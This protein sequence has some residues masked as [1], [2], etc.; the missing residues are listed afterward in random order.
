MKAFHISSFLLLS[1]LGVFSCSEKKAA[2]EDQDYL[3]ITI[4]NENR[5]LENIIAS[6]IEAR[7]LGA[8]Y[9]WTEGPLWVEEEKMLLFSEI[10]AN[11]VHV[12][13]EGGAPE[14]YLHPA[15]LTTGESRGGEVGSNGLLLDPNGKLVLCQHGDRGLARMMAELDAPRPEYESVIAEFDGKRFNSPNDA[16]FDS[17]GNLYF[18]DPA[19]GLEFRMED[20][21]KEIDFQGVY[22]YNKDGHLQLLLDS[23]SRPNGI[24]L[25]PDE[26]HLLI[27]NSDPEKPYWYLYELDGDEGLKN[28]RVFYD[29]S[30]VLANEPGLPDGLKIKKDGTIIASG[31]GGIW[32]FGSNGELLGRLKLKELVSNVALNGKEDLLFV[33]ADS[34]VLSIPLK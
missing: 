6:G 25:L 3:P 34:Y 27:A 13:K 23:I 10:P 14:V 1:A 2:E 19:Y 16:I 32:I 5:G 20:P 30:A 8:G 12:W 28:G 31:P 26:K 29:A 17:K 11:K 33:T 22:R 4:V 9:E 24:A 18:T 21:K 7:I 15:G